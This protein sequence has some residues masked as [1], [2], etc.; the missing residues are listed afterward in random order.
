LGRPANWRETLTPRDAK[1]RGTKAPTPKERGEGGDRRDR[2]W[3]YLATGCDAHP[4]LHVHMDPASIP[5]HEVKKVDHYWL[6]VPACRDADSGAGR[7]A[8]REPMKVRE[9]PPPLRGHE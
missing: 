6:S 5:W 1:R 2:Y 8:M 3:I 9:E 7:D 4:R